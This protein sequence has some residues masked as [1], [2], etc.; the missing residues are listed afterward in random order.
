[1][2]KITPQQLKK[3]VSS[4][5]FSEKETHE[6]LEILKSHE[7]LDD[8]GIFSALHAIEEKIASIFGRQIAMWQ[9]IDKLIDDNSKAIDAKFGKQLEN[10]NDTY[11]EK[12][13][14]SKT[15]GDAEGL[16]EWFSKENKRI[17]SE[18]NDEEK[19]LLEKIVR[20]QLTV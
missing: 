2:Q 12:N 19:M 9:K 6:M 20:S 17:Q 10:L 15:V 3:I 4:G 13:E 18:W 5:P 11:A 1:M 7:P 8:R 14:N 16:L